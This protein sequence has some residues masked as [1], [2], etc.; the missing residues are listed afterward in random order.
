MSHPTGRAARSWAE[1]AAV[2]AAWLLLLLLSRGGALGFTGVLGLPWLSVAVAFAALCLGPG[3]ALWRWLVGGPLRH[4]PAWAAGL[5]L[6]WVLLACT[7]CMAAGVTFAFTM[8]TVVAANGVLAAAFVVERLRARDA[9]EA[10]D[11][12]PSRPTAWL[13]AAVALVMARL[14]D[15][16][17]RRLNRLTYGGDEWAFLR[18]VRVFVDGTT[19]ADPHEFDAWDLAIALVVRLSRV[20]VFEAYRIHLPPLLVVAAALAF[21]VLAETLFLDRGLAWLALGVQGLYALSDMHTRGEGLG[22]ALLVR[23]GEDKNVALLLALPLAQAAFLAVLRGRGRRHL[24]AFALLALA[25][26]VMQPFAVPW[27]AF[28]C[29]VTYLLALATGLVPRSPRLLAALAGLAALAL[30]GA[31]ALRALRP[32]AYFA[33]NDAS[34][35]F[36]PTLVELSFRQLL[37]L[38]MQKGWYMAHP[39]LLTHPMMIAGLLA[40]L[41]FVRELR[42]SLQ[43]QWLVLGIWVPVLLVF[44]PLTAVLLGRVV[45]PWRLYRILWSMPVALVVAAALGLGLR[46]LEAALAPRWPAVARGGGARGPLAAAA[47]ALMALL[48]A[49]WMGEAGRALRARNRVLVKPSEKAFLHDLDV[50]AARRGLSGTVLA[51]EGLSVRLPAWTLRLQALPGLIAIRDRDETLLG[52]NAAFHEAAAIG[53]DQVALLRQRGIRYVITEKS[54]P[55]DGAL[56]ALPRAFVPLLV[57]EELALYEWRPDHWPG[58]R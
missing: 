9:E 16:G 56:R 34:W 30:A 24:V 43:A 46:R 32:H 37:I 19:V 44:D 50:L 45:T 21:L 23:V 12:A 38:S 53:P 29:G 48:L 2:A 42:V 17:T 3:L 26:T 33:V 52:A 55:V 58:P 49:P 8:A 41:L 31:A 22:M 13:V 51:P 27:L 6:A 10:A 1:P 47:L 7:A 15:V 14:L 57:G 25:A 11:P 36:N 40:S 5:G 18:A 39:W 4:A 35:S 20:E 28:T 54:S